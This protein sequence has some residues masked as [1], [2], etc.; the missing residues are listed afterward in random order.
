MKF[1]GELFDIYFSP[2][3]IP[4]ASRVDIAVGV[5][6]SK[7]A[8]VRNRLKRQ[9]REIL[10]KYITRADFPSQYYIKVSAKPSIIGR[11]FSYIKENLESILDRIK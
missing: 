6:V 9:T 5:K 7:K 11:R 10:R 3:K 8:V 1:T 4:A 2:A